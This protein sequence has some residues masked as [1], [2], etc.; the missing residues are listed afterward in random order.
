[1]DFAVREVTA[2]MKFSDEHSDK[3]AVMPK[4]NVKMSAI[5]GVCLLQ[6]VDIVFADA[7][8]D[9][10]DYFSVNLDKNDLETGKYKRK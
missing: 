8:R 4:V 10:T 9:S 7:L 2:Q 6:R 3:L 5:C 1:M